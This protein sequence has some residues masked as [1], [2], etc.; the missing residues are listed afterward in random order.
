MHVTKWIF[1][2][3]KNLSTLRLKQTIRKVLAFLKTSPENER[4]NVLYVE[5][6]VD[7]MWLAHKSDFD[8]SQ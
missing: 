3:K 6:L 8:E 5:I 1:F 7:F 4:D 2:F